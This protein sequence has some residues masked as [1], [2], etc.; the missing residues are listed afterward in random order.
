[1]LVPNIEV[2]DVANTANILEQLQDVSVHSI[3]CVN[4]KEE[5]PYKPD[6]SFKIAHNGSYLFLQFFVEEQEIMALAEHDNGPVWKD[7][8]VEFFISFNNSPSYYNLESSCIGKVLLGYRKDK[9][10]SAHAGQQTLESIKRY[11]SLG[12]SNFDK[13]EG[14][15]KWNILLVVPASAFWMS[16][17]ETF[18]GLEAR[19]NF[20]KCGDNLS[21]PHFLS[22]S[23]I[24]YHKPNFHLVDYFDTIKFE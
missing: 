21:T 11:P 1:M 8:C 19:A 4:W 6:V 14:D 12:T 20:Y 15:F 18:K 13:K 3:A 5:Y 9:S 24:K 22:W 23:P 16:E 17:I 10:D 7:S 2:V